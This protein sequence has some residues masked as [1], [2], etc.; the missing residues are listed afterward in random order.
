MHEL[1]YLIE[2]AA[3]GGYI[4][5]Y[6]VEKYQLSAAKFQAIKASPKDS[7]IANRHPHHQ[8]NDEAYITALFWAFF[9]IGRLVSIFIATKFSASFMIFIDI[10]K[11]KFLNYFI[12]TH[13]LNNLLIDWLLFVRVSDALVVVSKQSRLALHSHLHVG[14]ILKQYNTDYIFAGRDLHRNDTLVLLFVIKAFNQ[15]K[16]FFNF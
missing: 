10:V 16:K 12:S 7:K 6:A 15:F 11:I 8:N 9:S 2:K 5:S 13:N 14:L 4:F 3:H 1:N